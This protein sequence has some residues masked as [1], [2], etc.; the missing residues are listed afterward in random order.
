MIG[1]QAVIAALGETRQDHLAI[2]A[3]IATMGDK[4]VA[5][6]RVR[7]E[8]ILSFMRDFLK[9]LPPSNREERNQRVQ[10]QI[11]ERA[12]SIG[13]EVTVSLKQLE[14]VK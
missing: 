13:N 9:D 8:A 6:A 2:V 7:L 12:L 10:R 1:H 5:S 14:K 4:D 11:I 3:L